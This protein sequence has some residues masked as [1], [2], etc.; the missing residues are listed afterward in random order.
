MHRSTLAGDSK[1]WGFGDEGLWHGD[2]L[3]QNRTELSGFPTPPLCSRH[4]LR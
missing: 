1:S 4:E 2:E 3:V